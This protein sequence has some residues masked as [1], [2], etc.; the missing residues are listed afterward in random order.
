MKKHISLLHSLLLLPLISPSYLCVMEESETNVPKIIIIEPEEII[1]LGFINTKNEKKEKE[2]LLEKNQKTLSKKMLIDL[3]KKHGELTD[4]QKLD[5]SKSMIVAP[6]PTEEGWHG[7]LYTQSFLYS[8]ETIIYGAL[9]TGEFNPNNK[10]HIIALEKAFNLKMKNNATPDILEMLEYCTKYK[11][12]ID[13]N[14]RVFKEVHYYIENKTNEQEALSKKTIKEKNTN[15]V[16]QRNA[17]IKALQEE[18]AKRSQE[19]YMQMETYTQDFHSTFHNDA[20]CIRAYRKGSAAIHEIAPLLVFARGTQCSDKH[21]NN[22]SNY[23]LPTEIDNAITDK[24]LLNKVGLDMQHDQI[25]NNSWEY[26]E[27]LSKINQKTQDI[28]LLNL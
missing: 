19:L 24:Y 3:Q 25:V 9:K 18:I 23:I 22:Q 5:L 13:L 2:I 20:Q 17:I 27:K 21:P 1:D 4:S 12:R 26:L 7:T 28:K 10:T 15:F 16:L 14:Q 6:A 8:P 11:G